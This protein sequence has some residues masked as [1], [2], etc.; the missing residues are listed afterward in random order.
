[1]TSARRVP[2]SFSASNTSSTALA[3]ISRFCVGTRVPFE[4]LDRDGCVNVEPAL[5]HA[6]DKFVGDLRLP[7]DETG[8]CFKFTNALAKIA[9]GLGVKFRFGVNIKSLLM[10]GGKISGVETSEG[11]VTAERYVVA[12]GSY[13]P[14]LI[15]ALGL[16]A[17]IYPV[18][19]YSITAPIVDGKPRTGFNRSG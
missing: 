4:V 5:A 3:R 18:K 8:D 15:K 11:I 2:C 7:N 17:P 1:M 12:L 9:E 19:G 13:T 10:S 16:N 14:A 6:K